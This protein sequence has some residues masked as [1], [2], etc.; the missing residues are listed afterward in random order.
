[1]YAVIVSGG[2]QHRVSEGDVLTV[3]KI[4]GAEPGNQMELD[5]VLMIQDGSEVQVGRP[6]VPEAKVVAT[7]LEN[8]RGRKILVFKKKRRKQYRRTQ[9]HRQAFTKLRIDKIVAG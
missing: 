3:E 9:G 6:E 5:R 4:A 1:M 2:T 7:V 8:G